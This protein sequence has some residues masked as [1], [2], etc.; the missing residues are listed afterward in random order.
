MG[1]SSQDVKP[2]EFDWPMV[3]LLDDPRKIADVAMDRVAELDSDGDLQGTIRI[4]SRRSRRSVRV[5]VR[6]LP[7]PPHRT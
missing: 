6:Q 7:A 5:P 2:Y 3:L 4:C 1:Y